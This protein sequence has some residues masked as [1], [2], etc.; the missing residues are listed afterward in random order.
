MTPVSWCVGGTMQAARPGGRPWP[1]G[2]EPF[3]VI[4]SR[5]AAKIVGR[6]SRQRRLLV[7][8]LQQ[9]L[10]LH[11][12]VFGDRLQEV[13]AAPGRHRPIRVDD[14]LARAGGL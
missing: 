5:A 14:Q 3:S 2:P 11:E 8:A 13:G 4:R 12:N 10:A 6:L 1:G 9:P 7:Y